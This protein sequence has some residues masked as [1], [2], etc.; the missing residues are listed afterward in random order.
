VLQEKSA[1]RISTVAAATAMTLSAA[2]L[3][4][5]WIAAKV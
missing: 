1:T 2:T 3:V 5:A 4:G